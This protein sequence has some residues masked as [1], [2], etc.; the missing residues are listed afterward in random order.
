MHRPQAV[1]STFSGA[2]VL[3]SSEIN[4]CPSAHPG[5][6]SR[7]VRALFRRRFISENRSTRG[8]FR[9]G[10][11]ALLARAET[12]PDRRAE[13]LSVAEFDRLARLL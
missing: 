9:P 13:T 8:S 2:L 6:G 12:A 11:D 7:R 5:R 1:H 10:G 3:W 4:S